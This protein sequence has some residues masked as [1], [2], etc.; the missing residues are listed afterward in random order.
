MLN[1]LL[2]SQRKYFQLSIKLFF[3]EYFRKTLQSM[4]PKKRFTIPSWIPAFKT[5]TYQYDI[6]PPMYQEITKI[7]KR[8]KASVS[9]CAV[10]QVSTIVL[11]V[12][13]SAF[14][15]AACFQ[16][17]FLYRTDSLYVEKS[18]YD[19][20]LQK[21]QAKRFRN[22]PF[23]NIYLIPTKPHVQLSEQK[24]VYR[25]YY[26]RGFYSRH[27]WNFRT[28]LSHGIFNQSSQSKTKIDHHYIT[29]FKKCLW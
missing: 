5:P 28:H 6:T 15:F 25:I 17:D 20:Y 1:D 26:L 3:T 13:I 23:K 18:S 14:I 9:P 10:Y 16:K 2:K 27:G 7:I 24:W 29:G 11:K 12:P 4:N 21:R 19:S 8:M 22:C